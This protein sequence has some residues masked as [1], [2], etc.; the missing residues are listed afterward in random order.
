MKALA[1]EEEGLG[2]GDGV[3]RNVAAACARVVKAWQL[4]SLPRPPWAGG[5]ARLLCRAQRI[6]MRWF[7]VLA[8][9]L[10]A[11]ASH[12]QTVA[13]LAWLKG[14]WRSEAEGGAIVTEVWIAPPGPAMFGYSYTE[15]EGA[16]R[17]WE[18]T[19]IEMVDGW[20]HFVAM[21][22]GGA[23]VRFRM[24]EMPSHAGNLTNPAVFDN[25]E[26]DFPQT[27]EYHG[28][29]DRLTARISGADGADRITFNYRR[30]R[31]AANLRP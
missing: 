22:N 30:I 8:A 10:L 2:R 16:I 28:V 20:P 4:T 24:R 27:V 29:G 25:P 15:G 1:L 5:L 18:Q 7:I 23:P 26:H 13:D 3:E 19:R 31:C 14:C 17:G 12:A 21:P 6:R 11:P 9:V